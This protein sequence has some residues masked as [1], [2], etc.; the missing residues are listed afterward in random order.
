VAGER[1]EIPLRLSARSAG[2]GD[3]GLVRLL[4]GVE[5]DAAAAGLLPRSAA[6]REA[7]LEVVL[8]GASRDEPRVFRSEDRVVVGGASAD[9]SGALAFLR[10]LQVPPGIVKIRALVRDVATGRTGTVT[11][12]VQV[13]SP[14]AELTSKLTSAPVSEAV[15]PASP[16]SS[17]FLTR[18]LPLLA[19]LQAGSL[20]NAFEHRS[21]LLHF[22]PHGSWREARVLIA[23]PLESLAMVLDKASAEGSPMDVLALV[24][25]D[26]GR[27]AARFKAVW[28]I[29]R[30]L[31]A[32]APSTNVLF[33]QPIRL[34]PGR[35]V[36]STFLRAARGPGLSSR[37]QAF[38]VTP[39]APLALSSLTLISGDAEG[40]SLPAP[41]RE[42]ETDEAGARETDGALASLLEKAGRYVTAYEAGFRDLVAEETY[43]QWAGSTRRVTRAEIVYVSIPGPIPWTCF[44][45]VLEVDGLK[46]REREDRIRD[47]F[48]RQTRATALERAKRIIEE[49]ARYNVG[50][51]YRT[52]NIPT[53]PL[54]FLHP[55]NQD[56]F[57]FERKGRRS[58]AG[59]ATVE[60]LITERARPTLVSDGAGGDLPAIGRVFIDPELGTVVR[61]ITTFRVPSSRSVA[62][63]SVDYRPD[64]AL[65]LWLPTEMKEDYRDLGGTFDP[66]FRR[67]T[68]ATAR[69]ARYR[70][71]EVSVDEKASLPPK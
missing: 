33:Q 2:A 9:E 70:R 3:E 27:L 10:E 1:E 13:A 28:P 55:R 12:R 59:V 42:A 24:Q 16:R 47:L 56:R 64:A 8:V 6:D 46:V 63:L 17:E 43:T 4:A 44:R 34:P 31:Q 32:P 23:A 29:E 57:A 36:L 71:F 48:L 5:V 7:A 35:Y 22:A 39:A 11:L 30:N 45:D 65:G 51:A 49:S 53:L 50:Q 37:R 61:T 20:V 26:Q 66:V 40:P 25:D 18:D 67:P 62:R 41:A 19:A 38:E 15:D 68:E 58:L 54:L 60:V 52:A 21:D 14:G 69:Y